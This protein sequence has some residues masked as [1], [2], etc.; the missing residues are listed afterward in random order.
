MSEEQMRGEG[1]ARKARSIARLTG[2]GVPI[3][4]HLPWIEC[5]PALVQSLEA[6]ACR[7]MVICLLGVYAEPDGMPRDL[8]DKFLDSRGVRGDL[9]PRENEFLAKEIPSRQD[10]ASFTWQ[11]ECAHVLL[12]AMGYN[13]A[14]CAPTESCTAQGVSVIVAPRSLVQLMEESNFRSPQEIFDGADLIF[15]YH[16]AARNAALRH[17]EPPAGLIEAVCY[18]RHYAFNWLIDSGTN[19]DDVDTST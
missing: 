4:D 2:E 13:E 15:R 9:T 11:Y 6:V 3:I 8:L 17:E 12:W 18:Y 5:D 10:R 7:A 14:L 19:W 16:W 1:E